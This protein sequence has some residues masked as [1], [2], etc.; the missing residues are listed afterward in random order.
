MN[1]APK[2]V[3][4]LRDA[5]HLAYHAVVVLNVVLYAHPASLQLVVV[6]NVSVVISQKDTHVGKI[7]ELIV[8]LAIGVVV[9][10]K[11]NVLSKTHVQIGVLYVAMMVLITMAVVHADT[12]IVKEDLV[13]VDAVTPKNHTVKVAVVQ[14]R[15]ECLP[16]VVKMLKAMH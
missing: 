14:R 1:V 16:V 15:Q 11:E 9:I 4:V 3:V 7:A 5:V 8:V 10:L 2:H 12:R 6:V 13:V